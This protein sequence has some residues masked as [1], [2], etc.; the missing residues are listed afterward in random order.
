MARIKFDVENMIILFLGILPRR[1]P[2]GGMVKLLRVG[3]EDRGRKE[4]GFGSD[5]RVSQWTS[6]SHN[7]GTY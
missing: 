5:D 2:D 7:C 3:I 4:T 1:R 6:W